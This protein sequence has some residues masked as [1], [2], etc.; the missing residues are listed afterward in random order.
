MIEY[1]LS[2]AGYQESKSLFDE[3]AIYEIHRYTMGYPRRITMVCHKALKEMIIQ[4]KQ[5]MTK[6]MIK[7]LIERE[8][9][10]LKN[11]LDTEKVVY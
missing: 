9:G 3:D 2:R 11:A 5:V 6:A 4:K 1:R 7:E 10:A 8:S